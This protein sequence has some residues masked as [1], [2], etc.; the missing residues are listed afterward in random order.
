MRVATVGL[1]YASYTNFLEAIG[2]RKLEI[3]NDKGPF[4]IQLPM[5]FLLTNNSLEGLCVFVFEIFT[6]KHRD[7]FWLADRAIIAPTNEAVDETN[8]LIINKFPEATVVY[9]SCDSVEESAHR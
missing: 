7:H 9:K 6:E 1:D 4:K 2:S 5:S 3:Q 8:E